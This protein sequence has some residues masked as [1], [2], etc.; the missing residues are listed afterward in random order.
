ML[1]LLM[2]TK[3]RSQNITKQLTSRSAQKEAGWQEGG[4][5]TIAANMKEKSPR[6]QSFEKKKGIIINTFLIFFYL[7]WVGIALG[8]FCPKSMAHY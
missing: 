2:N 6:L 1:L 8:K 7:P 3:G 4:V 5:A